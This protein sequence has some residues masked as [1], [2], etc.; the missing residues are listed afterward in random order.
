MNKTTL[1]WYL[2]KLLLKK[3]ISLYLLIKNTAW[4]VTKYRV[5]SSLHF[6]AFGLNMERSFGLN[7]E[8]Y[9]VSLRIQSE[10]SLHIQSECGKIRTR[11]NSVFGQFSR[12][13]WPTADLIWDSY[14][15][16]HFLKKFS[17]KIWNIWK[18]N[19]TGY[20]KTYNFACN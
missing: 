11:K 5:F 9:S 14:S 7:T 1:I 16:M 15:T 8:R 13:K 17:W 12:I 18:F 3:Q 20:I 4:K 19:F 10:W 2:L 6:P